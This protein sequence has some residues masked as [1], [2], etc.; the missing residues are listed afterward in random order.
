MGKIKYI[1]LAACIVAIS[2][3][4][5]AFDFSSHGYYRNRVEFTENLDTQK[6]WET[7]T[8]N[9]NRFGMIN[10]NEMR[11]RIEP[12]LKLNDFLSIMTQMDILDNVVFGSSDTKQLQIQSPVVGTVT[13]PAGAGSI[14]MVG[15]AAGENGSVNVR[16]VWAEV[17]TPVGQLRVGRQPSNWGLG[18]FQNDGNGQQ[19]DF[20]DTADRILFLT[21]KQFSNGGAVNVGALWDIA[22]EAQF[23]PRIQGL[24]GVIRDNGQDASQYAFIADYEHPIGN[25]GLFAGVRKRDGGSAPTMTA[26]AFDAASPTGL[27][28]D[29]VP[30]GIDGNTLI[31]FFDITG[32]YNYEEYSFETEFVYL[33]GRM[34]TGLAIDAIP[35]A[36]V[37]PGPVGLEGIIQLP[38]KQDV[39]VFM[40]AFEAKAKYK[41]GGEW[42]F[43]AGFA[44]GDATPLSQ[45]ITQ[46][47]FRPD[48]QIALFMFNVPIGTSPA[49]IPTGGPRA[50]S[51]VAGGLPITGN[52]INNAI[53][54]AGGY[55]HHFDVGDKCKNCNDLA[56]GLKVIS[57]FAQK[58][59]VEL[60]FG[61]LLSDPTL[62]AIRS[63][64][65][66]YG[67]ECDL[68]AE[69][70]FFDHLYGAI[71][72]GVL[73]PGNAYN[74]STDVIDPGGI[75]APIAF[76]GAV[77]AYGGRLSMILDF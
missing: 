3:Q 27:T 64:G 56:L 18:I 16:R 19:A 66:W 48:Y 39:R 46:Y 10:W 70:R 28:A 33:G 9:N 13:L 53:Y 41:W 23:D 34:T 68:I 20:G 57:A 61:A 40:A 52:F 17:L 55:K 65:K 63:R 4:V 74:I 11:L 5:Q 29:P 69:G 7:P 42:K 75:I 59:P 22:Y 14:S 50:G 32:R 30:A 49:I 15:G 76:S 54:F 72:A 62:P 35:L 37:M 58:P 51:K 67:V 2:S 60:D 77:P 73:V 26:Y 6:P 31:Y 36:A 71:E 43:Q 45:R 21:Q 38:P 8:Y 12:T 24:G 1:F 44:E 25:V 47:G